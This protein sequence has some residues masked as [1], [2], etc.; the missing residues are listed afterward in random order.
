MII[1]RYEVISRIFITF[2]S[3]CSK[4]HNI[5]CSVQAVT[6]EKLSREHC[7]SKITAS[8]LHQMLW[9]LTQLKMK[10]MKIRLISLQREMIIIIQ[11]MIKFWDC[12]RIA[13]QYFEHILQS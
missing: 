10:V 11:V 13:M 1:S 7:F 2:I 6:S 8:T 12:R 9:N 3:K 5:W 4:F